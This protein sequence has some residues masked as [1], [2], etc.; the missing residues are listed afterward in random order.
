MPAATR[1][2][3]H[4]DSASLRELTR[5][6]EGACRQLGD[7]GRAETASTL[8]AAA[9]AAIRD[10][11]PREAD[12]FTGLL[13]R[14]NNRPGGTPAGT[15]LDPSE[16]TELDVRSEPPARRH[17]LI[18]EAFHA[19]RSGDGFVLVNDHDPKPLYYQFAAEYPDCFDW[20][21]LEEGPDVWR[22]YIG[23]RTPI[24][25]TAVSIPMIELQS[26]ATM[27]IE[28]LRARGCDSV[29][30]TDPDAAGAWERLQATLRSGVVGHTEP[31]D[32][33]QLLSGVGRAADAAGGS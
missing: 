32:L 25:A 21:S 17:Q 6:L 16:A 27:V 13:H 20:E 29:V 22:V 7:A 14:L 18:F 3:P 12:R 23:S 2:R 4:Q 19:L 24:A 1:S 11:L 5:L 9:W 33:A 30:V 8:A 26:L 31:A 28:G 10:E 15:G